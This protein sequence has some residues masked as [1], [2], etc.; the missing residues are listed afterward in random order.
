MTLTRGL[1][2]CTAWCKPMELIIIKTGSTYLRVKPDAFIEVN[3]DKASVFP[4][5]KADHVKALAEQAKA[6]GFADVHLK[7]LILTETDFS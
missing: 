3:L 2:P 6:R 1:P 5:E 7:K 4:M